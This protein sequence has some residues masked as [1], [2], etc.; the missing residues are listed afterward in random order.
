[1]SSPPRREAPNR[2]AF[3]RDP[4]FFAASMIGI[5]AMA[6]AGISVLTGIAA[7]TARAGSNNDLV[8]MGA[9]KTGRFKKLLFGEIPDRV[10]RH[11]QTS[12]T[13]VKRREGP[14]K[15]WPRGTMS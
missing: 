14:A 9:A 10:G 2:V 7:G 3:A 8:V 6:G 12:V 4:G 5:G 13:L 11:A 1:M 15:V